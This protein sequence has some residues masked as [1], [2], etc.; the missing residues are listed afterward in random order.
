MLIEHINRVLA[1]GCLRALPNDEQWN[2]ESHYLELNF[3]KHSS[4][5]DVSAHVVETRRSIT[6]KAHCK[7]ERD[8]EGK[9]KTDVMKYDRRE[10]SAI[11]MKLSSLVFTQWMTSLKSVYTRVDIRRV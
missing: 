9:S 7:D 2:I 1:L 4:I 6:L 3:T 11:A 10:A 8:G 5:A